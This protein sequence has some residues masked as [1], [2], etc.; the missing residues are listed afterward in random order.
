MSTQPEQVN[1]LIAAF[2]SLKSYFE[3]IRTSIDED[4]NR[5]KNTNP[6]IAFSVRGSGDK[7]VAGGQ[8]VSIQFTSVSNNKGNG[9]SG[10]FENATFTAPK[11]GYYSLTIIGGFYPSNFAVWVGNVGWN[12]VGGEGVFRTSQDP[13]NDLS[14]HTTSHIKKLH[15]TIVAYIEAGVI[16]APQIQHDGGVNIIRTVRG[17]LCTAHGHFIGE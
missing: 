11:T 10:S 12:K 5:F 14:N 1:G 2:N 9:F 16:I 15:V 6:T 3:G 13:Y 4:I 17:H 8:F 7:S